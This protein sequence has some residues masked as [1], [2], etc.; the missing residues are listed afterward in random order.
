AVGSRAWT[1][2]YQQK[3]T[4]DEGAIIKREWWRTYDVLPELAHTIQVWDTAFKAKS[5]S[6]WSV[7]A[8]WGAGRDGYY[9][10]DRWRERVT[11]PDLKRK[12]VELYAAH[13]PQ[14]IVIE[15]AASGQ[16][17]IQELQRDTSLPVIGYRPDKDKVAR[18]NAVT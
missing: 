8:T 5:T 9:L 15:D 17:L 1:A 16:S 2:L 7:C 6:D 11:F 18:V 14:A 13:R 12:A 10:I 3:P 4:D